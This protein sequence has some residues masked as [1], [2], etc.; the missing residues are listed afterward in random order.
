[1]QQSDPI[2]IS[3]SHYVCP[4]DM[5]LTTFLDVITQAG[6]KSVGLTVRALDEM[7]VNQMRQALQARGL[8]VS[9]VNTAGY[10][11]ESHESVA[12]QSDLNRRLLDAAAELEA[13]NGVNLIVGSSALLPLARTRDQALA[14]AG[15]LAAMAKARGTRLLLEPMHPLLALTKGCVNTLEQAAQWLTAIP[16]LALNID[17]FH[18]WWDPSLAAACQ[19]HCGEVGMIQICDLL[20]NPATN[21]P[22]RAPLDEGTLDWASLVELALTALPGTPIELE[23]FANQMPDRDAIAV[24]QNDAKLMRTLGRAL[25]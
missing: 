18:S 2:N 17:L 20:I 1:M 11:F 5:D 15:E 19:G 6:F 8:G 12:K 23:W 13:A 21:L 10:F 3:V 24:M 16:D 22:R 9:S 4:S 14:L 25:I 7:P